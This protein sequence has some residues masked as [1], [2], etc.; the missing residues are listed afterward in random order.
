MATMYSAHVELERQRV[1]ED[2]IDSLMRALQTF[3]GAVG[4]SPR[5][6]VDAQIS[7]PAENLTQAAAIAVATVEAAARGAGMTAEA[8]AIE[9]MT[10]SEWNVREGWED[11]EMDV[12]DEALA[13]PSVIGSEETAK[14]LGVSR[15]RVMQLVNEGQLQSVP[16]GAR[17]RGF[18]RGDVVALARDRER[19]MK[20]VASVPGIVRHEVA[21]RAHKRKKARQA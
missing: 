3:H 7:V 21:G 20:A 4:K 9:V 1:S 11:D 13:G 18:I 15:Q 12:L 5:G 8:L 10:E 14:I 6:W 16:I 2:Q 19:L 17:A